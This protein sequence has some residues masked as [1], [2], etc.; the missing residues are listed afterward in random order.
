MRLIE[1]AFGT[2]LRIPESWDAFTYRGL[3]YVKDAFDHFVV[4]ERAPD[5]APSAQPRE[6]RARD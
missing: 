2:V 6:S 3:L 5:D 4:Q 1:I